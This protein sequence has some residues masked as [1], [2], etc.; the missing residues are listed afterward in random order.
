MNKM[1][2]TILLPKKVSLIAYSDPEQGAILNQPD[3]SSFHI[4]LGQPLVIPKEAV[5]VNVSVVQ[6]TIWNVSYNITEGVNDRFDV[7]YYDSGTTNTTLIDIKIPSGRYD[8]QA[9]NSALQK[10]IDADV[11]YWAGLGVTIPSSPTLVTLLSDTATQKIN[12]RAN[13]AGITINFGATG[14]M[15][16][17]LGFVA[18]TSTT[19]SVNALEIFESPNPAVFNSLSYYQIHSDLVSQGLR[20]NTGYE[21]AVC[22]VPIN[23]STGSQI[24][25]EPS[26]PVEI[27]SDDLAGN[28]R[29]TIRF[30]LTDES[31]NLI[32]TPNEFWSVHLVINYLLPYKY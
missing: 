10:A 3:G 21:Q 29:N 2:S 11:V 16:D 1:S 27:G 30:W 6:S 19:Q 13:Y 9:L 24:L 8:L 32:S 17:L 12:I 25:Y 28:V 22:L 15:N 4:V 31:N 7:S 20:V 5:N 23:V 26:N 18:G 14:Y